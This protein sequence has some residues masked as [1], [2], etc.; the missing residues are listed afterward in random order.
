LKYHKQTDHPELVYRTVMLSLAVSPQTD[1]ERRMQQDAIDL[2]ARFTGRVSE[3][4]SGVLKDPDLMRPGLL[5]IRALAEYRAERRKDALEYLDRVDEEDSRLFHALALTCRAAIE[6]DLGHLDDSRTYWKNAC[7][8]RSSLTPSIRNVHWDL[9]LL[10]DLLIDQASPTDA[11]TQPAVER[12]EAETQDDREEPRRDDLGILQEVSHQDAFARAAEV[13]RRECLSCHGEKLQMSGLRLDRRKDAMQVIEPGHSDDSL[14]VQRIVDRDLGILMPP[15]FDLSKL[16]AKDLSVLKAWIDAGAPWPEGKALAR[17]S[18]ASDKLEQ[19]QRLR[20]HLRQGELEQS[21]QLLRAE[22]KLMEL[23]D[24]EGSTVLHAACLYGDVEF[25]AFLIDQGANVKAGDAS[26]ITPLMLACHDLKKT[27]L[28]LDAGANASAV[29][30]LGRSTLE[31][32][33]SYSGNAAVI[34]RLLSSQA[35]N[36]DTINKALQQSVRVLDSEMVERLIARGGQAGER[37]MY[38]AG[39]S[40][41]MRLIE[42]LLESVV[43]DRRQAALD[44]ALMGAAID[45][46]MDKVQS[47]IKLGANPTVAL[48]SATYSEF[49]NTAIVQALLEAGADPNQ[50]ARVLSPKSPKTSLFVAKRHGNPNVIRLLTDSKPD[51]SQNGNAGPR[52]TENIKNGQEADRIQAAVAKGVALL[53]TC[54]ETFFL[55]TGCMACHQQS[56]TALAVAEARLH[57][58][59]VDEEAAQRELDLVRVA[60]K[61]MKSRRLQRLEN[62][63]AQPATVGFYALAFRA[64]GYE[65][66]ES[67]DAMVIDMAGRQTPDGFWIAFTHRPP[68]EFSKIK[69]TAFAVK[70]MQLYGP[71]SYRER[72]EQRIGKARDWLV[73]SKPKGNEEEVFRLLGLAWSGAGSERVQEQLDRLSALQQDDGGW[74]QLPHLETDA[75]ATAMALYALHEAGMETDSPAYQKGV[76]YLLQTQTPEGSWHVRS[77]SEPVQRYF[78]S[79]FPHGKDQWISATATGWA[80]I[81]LLRSLGN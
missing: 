25:V 47:L 76:Q 24:E 8:V 11:V 70:A 68:I 56:V 61:N 21:R 54:D 7:A 13:L 79:G 9:I 58:L 72:F 51:S 59:D 32:A 49:S 35:D 20:A 26:G 77:R 37:T 65:P 17:Q 75:Y 19:V 1:P 3:E 4:P 14:L 57:G 53:Q 55:K 80:S 38:F 74:K 44:N 12:D 22:P 23:P 48:A 69:S 50:A 16:P 73:D 52:S 6:R 29:T 30:R 62:P 81:V 5:F 33:A 60:L 45:G 64:Q 36:R 66:D 28:L 15:T 71:P 67:T 39:R 41:G 2:A 42:T 27:D 31:I 10:L 43:K 78:E 40:A 18:V 46:S 34:D 63:F